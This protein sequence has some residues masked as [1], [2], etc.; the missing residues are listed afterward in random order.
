MVLQP[1]G[2]RDRVKLHDIL[3]LITI[4]NADSLERVWWGEGGE[5]YRSKINKIRDNAGK[6]L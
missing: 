2:R 1:A 5:G 4:I 3:I 6:L